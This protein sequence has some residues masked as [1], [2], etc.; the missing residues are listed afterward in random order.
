MIDDVFGFAIVVVLEGGES[1]ESKA[2][3][4]LMTHFNNNR[5]SREF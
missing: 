2:G 4:V 1:G 5:M 3:L